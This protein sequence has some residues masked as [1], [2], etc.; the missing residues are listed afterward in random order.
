[1]PT[2]AKIAL[3]KNEFVAVLSDGRRIQQRDWHDLAEA[4]FC[5]GVSARNVEYEWHAGQR[6][7]TAGQQVALRAEIRR[8]GHAVGLHEAAA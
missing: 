5:A 3:S 8:L 2:T 6:M 4:L 7:I 1:M